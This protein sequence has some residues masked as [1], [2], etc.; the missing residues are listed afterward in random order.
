MIPIIFGQQQVQKPAEFQKMEPKEESKLKTFG[1]TLTAVGTTMT[2]YGGVTGNLPLAV[3]GLAVTGI[4]GVTWYAGKKQAEARI[5][6]GIS[7]KTRKE[8]EKINE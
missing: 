8:L 6:L 2:L 7:E 3:V 4:G 5:N 1:K